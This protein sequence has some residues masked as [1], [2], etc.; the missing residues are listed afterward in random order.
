MD[1]GGDVSTAAEQWRKAA[2]ENILLIF[3]QTLLIK[4]HI[5]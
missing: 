4:I 5:L 1:L 2:K 3:D